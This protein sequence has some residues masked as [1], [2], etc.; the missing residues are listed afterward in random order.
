MFKLI[1]GSRVPTKTRKIDTLW[2][3]N[4]CRTSDRSQRKLAQ[5]L[6]IDPSAVSLMFRGERNM[7]LDEAA[8]IAKFF[9]VSYEEVLKRAGIPLKDITPSGGRVKIA[10]TIDAHGVVTSGVHLGDLPFV[11]G[12]NDA[13]LALRYDTSFTPAEPYDHW[14]L[15]YIPQT[16]VSAE[17]VGRL[18]VVDLADNTRKV[19]FVRRA[20]DG[21]EYALSDLCGQVNERAQV[22]HASPVLFI[23]P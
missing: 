12:A 9:G 7:Q 15:Y 23:R 20:F 5:T 17:A 6:G 18:C 1:E 16:G 8:K 10:G 22:V 2:F 11:R 4:M 3:Q 21:G 19:R 13:T 14:C